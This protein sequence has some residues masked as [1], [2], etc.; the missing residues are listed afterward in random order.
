MW[1]ILRAEIEYNIIRI[2]I[3]SAFILL[4]CF[5][6]LLVIG[7]REGYTLLVSYGL[8]VFW[9][10]FRNKERRGL[11]QARLPLSIKQLALS[12]FILALL[13]S[14]GF[15]IL[16]YLT[17]F[18]FNFRKPVQPEKL[19]IYG[20][21]I[22]FGASLYFIFSD[23]RGKSSEKFKH[24]KTRIKAVMI[25]L[26]GGLM[27]LTFYAIFQFKQTGEV[28]VL[29]RYLDYINLFFEPPVNHR[30]MIIFFI[31]SLGLGYLTVFT[32][33]WRKNYLN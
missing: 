27:F 8:M 5:Y 33:S 3:F 29:L 9:I 1:R 25:L 16:Y 19:I 26:V 17:Y 14:F 23:L 30:E 10:T 22:L 24:I 6:E 28:P 12:R 7:T 11:Q 15:S 2:L 20:C 18:L 13:F 21:I 32:F 31:L 4:I